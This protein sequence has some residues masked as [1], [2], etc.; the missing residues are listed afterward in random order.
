MLFRHGRYII[1][2]VVTQGYGYGGEG[3]WKVSAMTAVMKDWMMEIE[4]VHITRDTTAESLEEQLFLNDLAWKLRQYS[5][6]LITA[7]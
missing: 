5:R 7:L 2:T 3:G 4:F 6:F 1:F